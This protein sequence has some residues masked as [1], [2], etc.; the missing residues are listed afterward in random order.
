MDWIYLACGMDRW[1]DRMNRVVNQQVA[2]SD[3]NFVTR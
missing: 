1:W 3:R 2:Y